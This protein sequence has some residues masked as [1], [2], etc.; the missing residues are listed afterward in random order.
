[1]KFSQKWWGIVVLL[2]AFVATVSFFAAQ[3]EQPSALNVPGS[4]KVQSEGL[5]VQ[6]SSTEL[7]QK[8][9]TL[10]SNSVRAST[11][12]EIDRRFNELRRKLLD[13]REKAIDWWL[14]I[15]VIFLTFLAIIIP[16]AAVFGGIFGFKKF[17]EIK[18]EA[19]RHLED[20]KKSRAKADSLVK[21]IS[22]EDAGTNP[23]KA[24]EVVENVHQ[25]PE[26]T[27][28]ERAVVAALSLQRQ[29]KI[30]KA[31]EK[32]RAV[33]HIAEESDINFATRAWLSVAYLL[34]SKSKHD[35]EE[36]ID[37]YDKALRLKPDYVEAYYNRGNT[38]NELGQFE[39][40]LDDYDKALRLKPDFPEAYN[41]RGNINKKLGKIEAALAD[42][43][44]TLR[45]NPDSPETYVNRGM[46]KDELGQIEAALVDYDEALRL[47]PD[48]AEA[49][50]NRGIAKAKLNLLEE[51]KQDFEK[52]LNLARLTG[53][54][55][56]IKAA[57]GNL[58]NL[59]EGVS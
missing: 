29:G 44:E 43:D 32:W 49:Y 47:K 24:S 26:A 50:N 56:L 17:N 46:V 13:D 14:T 8:N 51:A 7:E 21:G 35:L 31:I 10:G 58:E 4:S 20:I 55:D 25:N 38:K 48:Y 16:I 54:E 5:G 2:F 3:T 1:M 45:L 53:N 28:I 34:R 57:R 11:E 59:D 33:A 27:L 42:Y 39:A 15:I 40:A 23:D 22:A 12:V 41:N 36:I 6:S 37:I 30:E 19:Q 52:M 18:E 9:P